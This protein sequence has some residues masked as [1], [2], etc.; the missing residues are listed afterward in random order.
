MRIL[1]AGTGLFTL[2]FVIACGSEAPSSS[3]EQALATAAEPDGK[4]LYKQYCITCHGLYGNMGASGAYNLQESELNVE[5]RVHVITKG[6]NA[7]N[8]F[9]SLLSPEEIRAVAEYTFKLAEK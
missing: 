9:E 6:R 5:E 8:A 7:M 1:L 4:A 2:L 3:E